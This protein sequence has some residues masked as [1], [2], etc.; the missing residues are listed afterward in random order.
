M[1]A[2]GAVAV[3]VV[4]MGAPDADAQIYT[5]RN[6][7]GVIEATNV[8]AER[9]YQLT[10]P[11]K[12]TLIHSA[13]WRL[14]PN[15]NGEFDHHIA[16]AAGLHNVS[17]HLVRAVIQ[18]ESDFDSLARSSKGAQGLM[19]LM[20]YTAREMGVSNAFDPRQNIF[21]GVRY[22]RILLDM[23][24]GD[25]SLATAAYNSGATNVQRYNGVPPFK[26][27][28]SYVAKIQGLL[29]GMGVPSGASTGMTSYAPGENPFGVKAA[30]ARA[31]AAKKPTKVTPARPRT[32]Y[33]W[34]DASG[35][36][37]VAQEPPAEGVVYST[38]R[39]LD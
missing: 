33:R 4:M 38:I 29:S 10:Y 8:P 34:K 31:A 37:H 13:A 36:M 30:T 9:G 25:V 39:A 18:V 19:Q 28:R 21:A 22:L 15:Y 17:T 1:A 3:A 26:E 27:T 11:G 2:A 32:Y 14:R 6:E 20:P 7:H 16:A 23:F 35:V 24:Q 12:G 5:R